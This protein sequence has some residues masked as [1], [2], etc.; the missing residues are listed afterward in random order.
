[1]RLEEIIWEVFHR[2]ALLLQLMFA[3]AFL[4]EKAKSEN[5]YEY[6]VCEGE[7]MKT[8]E[9]KASTLSPERKRVEREQT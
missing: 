4:F 7:T 5:R 3:C 6:H 9:R 2:L 1:M 8:R